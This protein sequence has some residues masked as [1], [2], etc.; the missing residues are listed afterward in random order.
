MILRGDYP[1]GTVLTEIAT[2]EDLGV[3]RT[4]VRFAFRIL[5][6][7]G[8]LNPSGARGY[9]VRE[10]TQKDV[11]HALQMRGILEGEAAR[12]L[13]EQGLDP[14]TERKLSRCLKEEAQL[15]SG[16][17]FT[18]KVAAEYNRLNAE[19]HN[20]IV[21]ATGSR[22]LEAAIRHLDHVPTGIRAINAQPHENEQEYVR[23]LIAHTQHCIILRAIQNGDGA[24]AESVMREHAYVRIDYASI[25]SDALPRSGAS[26]LVM[27]IRDE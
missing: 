5:E 20:T 3:S 11:D 6:K 13:A 23:L 16:W 9:A 12:Q 1:P 4:P 26:L 8:F 14:E 17:R 25:L 22:Q 15:F 24:R 19:F 21:T 2:S 18:D 7:E 27:P 10:V